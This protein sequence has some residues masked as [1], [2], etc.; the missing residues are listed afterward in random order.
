MLK[1]RGEAVGEANNKV[2]LV[3]NSWAA[4]A[5]FADIFGCLKRSPA[6]A[7]LRHA[8]TIEARAFAVF[9]IATVWRCRSD[10]L[11]SDALCLHSASRILPLFSSIPL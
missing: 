6:D 9:A 7:N 8:R 3:W 5:L 1:L 11:N 4:R 2:V 10:L